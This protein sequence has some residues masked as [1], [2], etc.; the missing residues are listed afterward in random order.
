M[1]GMVTVQHCFS[2]LLSFPSKRLVLNNVNIQQ[3]WAAFGI[4]A[5]GYALNKPKQTPW[6]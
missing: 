6:P 5:L 3:Q 1:V 4:V 2:V